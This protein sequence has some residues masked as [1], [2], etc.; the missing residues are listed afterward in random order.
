MQ[1]YKSGGKVTIHKRMLH[2]LNIGIAH[3]DLY[4]LL[5]KYYSSYWKE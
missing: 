3:H 1:D 5:F 4:G 2:R